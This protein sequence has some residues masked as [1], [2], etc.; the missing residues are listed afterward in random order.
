M[1]SVEA[2]WREAKD[3]SGNRYFWHAHTR[4]RR[5]ERPDAHAHVALERRRLAVD[6]AKAARKAERAAME[7]EATETAAAAETAISA[8]KPALRRWALEAGWQFGKQ[9]P[10]KGADPQRVL[11]SLLSTVHALPHC[12]VKPMAVDPSSRASILKAYKRA[13]FA[14]HSDKLT[15]RPVE[16]RA[17]SEAALAEISAAKAA[18]T[19]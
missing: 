16:E 6:R 17:I 14:L 13:V 19:S 10:S 2:A 7:R 4:E 3:G 12:T 11:A 15:G 5:W 9:R 18:M 8:T 1:L